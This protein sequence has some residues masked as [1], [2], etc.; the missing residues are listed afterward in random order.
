MAKA[1][2]MVI[3]K[4]AA[5][6]P[7]VVP[8]TNRV[9]GLMATK[10]MMNGIGRIILINKFKNEKMNLFSKILPLRV[11][12]SSSPMIIPKILAKINVKMTI[13]IVSPVA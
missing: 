2:A 11:T 9:S 1:A 7:I 13:V 12:N 5:V 6:V 4:I 8:T 10:N 3:G